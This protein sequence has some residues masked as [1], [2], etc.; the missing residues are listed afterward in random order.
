MS[1]D[2]ILS[3]IPNVGLL[4]TLALIIFIAHRAKDVNFNAFDYLIDP[5][6]G[7]A[8]ITKTLQIV[9]GV[10]ATWIVIRLA[11]H[12]KLSVEM[13]VVYLCALGVSEAWSKFVGAKYLTKPGEAS[14]PPDQPLNG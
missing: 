11:I 14:P 5:S 1:F 13:F 4:F 8:S 12:D 2:Q 7:K 3:Y 10:T 6:T 9:A